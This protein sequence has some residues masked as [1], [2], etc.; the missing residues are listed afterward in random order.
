LKL[1]RPALVATNLGL[2]GHGKHLS[3]TVETP[4]VRC[5]VRP[6]GPPNGRLIDLDHLIHMLQALKFIV[7]A[8]FSAGICRVLC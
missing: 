5:R 1:N 2:I 6:G 8:R 4:C 7:A 3:D